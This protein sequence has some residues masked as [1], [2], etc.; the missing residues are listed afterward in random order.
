MKAPKLKLG[1]PGEDFEEDRRQVNQAFIEARAV[2][3]RY[4]FDVVEALD[5]KDPFWLRGR[6]RSAC[7]NGHF[8]SIEPLVRRC[9]QLFPDEEEFPPF[10]TPVER[11]LGLSQGPSAPS[12]SRG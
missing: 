7:R 8:E 10:L 11:T 5:Q 1:P 2:T 4:P 6:V 3:G 9:C 12:R